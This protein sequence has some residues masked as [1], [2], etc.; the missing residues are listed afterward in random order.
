MKF[1]RTREG[2]GTAPVM[3]IELFFDLV[4]AFAVTQ[5]SSTLR[6]HLSALGVLHT[7]MLFGAVW[8][9]WMYTAW[10]TNWLNPAE[11]PVRLM[12][13]FLTL[14]G[15]GLSVALPNAFGAHGLA[16]ALFYAGL[17]QGRNA[18]LAFA[19]RPAQ[20][21]GFLNIIRIL[22][23]FTASAPFWV[24]GGLLPDPWRTL[25]WLAALA[26]DF[27]GPACSFW[28]PRMGKSSVADWN[29]D[30]FHMADRC[31]AFILMALGESMTVTGGAFFTMRWGG[32]EAAAL[33]SAFIGIVCLWW[34]Y[35]DRAAEYGAQAFAAAP[36]T[37]RIARAAYTYAHAVLVAGIIVTAAADAM[38]LTHPMA[39]TGGWTGFLVIGGPAIFLAGSVAF[40][41]ALG[42][43]MPP[44]HKYGLALLAALCLWAPVLPVLPLAGAA[45]VALLLVIFLSEF[46]HARVAQ[47]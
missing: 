9:V 26:I 16:F 36:D 33:L 30:S 7:T 31:A 23:W 6:T 22:V 47:K 25:L 15:L 46:L 41:W 1:L 20:K 3:Q 40:R 12:L 28:V 24:A 45:S 27:T 8:W 18:F 17:Q 4:F 5:L 21:A 32:V 43:Y 37:G 44:S 10:A 11:R 29:I 13:I 19:F 39:A 14:G 38:V 34:I 42:R 35:F 2:H